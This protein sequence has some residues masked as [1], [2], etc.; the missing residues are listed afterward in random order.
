M[1]DTT[2]LTIR[3][4]PKLLEALDQKLAQPGESRS[5]TIRRVLE[6]AL[7]EEQ[8]PTDIERYLQGYRDQPQTEAEFGW[9]DDA[10]KDS[11]TAVP[12]R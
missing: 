3:M 10:L 8:A 6:D 5:A 11:L 9:S 2:R 1:N 12:W 7:R 4:P